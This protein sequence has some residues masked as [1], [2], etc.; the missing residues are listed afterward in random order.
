[1]T[2]QQPS[3]IVKTIPTARVVHRGYEYWCEGFN[4]PDSHENGYRYQVRKI[5]TTDTPATCHEPFDM[6]TK[7]GTAARASIDRLLAVLSD[8]PLV[9]TAK[10]AAPVTAEEEPKPEEKPK[11]VRKAKTAPEEVAPKP[12][13]S[14]K[15]KA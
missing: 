5:G 3:A 13:R 1:M 15:P 12:K 2:Q 9:E 14:P 8:Q 7:A 10:P 6:V 11:R 4:D